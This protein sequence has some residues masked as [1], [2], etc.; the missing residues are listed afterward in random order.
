MTGTK[1]SRI[2]LVGLLAFSQSAYAC[3]VPVFRYA[4]ERWPAANYDVVLFH[5]GPLNSEEQA[6]RVLLEQAQG[7]ANVT[8]TPFDL[9]TNTDLS[10][11]KLWLRQSNAPLPRLVVRF[12]DS[13]SDASAA[14][15]GPL[16]RLTVQS[17]IDSPSR[18]KITGSL[19]KGDSAVWLLL[20]TGSPAQN[21][22][23]AALLTAELKKMETRLELPAPAPDDPPMRSALPLRMAFSVLRLSPQ[24]PA[25]G[26]FLRL[27]LGGEKELAAQKEPIAFPI[28][29][30][31]RMLAAL[32]AH[33]LGPKLI[34]EA[35]S[36]I[37][38]ACSCEVKDLS[39]GRDLLLSA[40]WNSIFA[41]PP[42]AEPE[43]AK[44]PVP[45]IAAGALQLAAPNSVAA[46]EARSPNRLLI[47]AISAATLL[48]LLTAYNAFKQ[49]FK[50]SA[51]GVTGP[52][53]AEKAKESARRP[54]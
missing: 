9:T 52:N 24:D 14:W 53:E 45:V 22:A 33:E 47:A 26:V 49:P 27:L 48:V 34:S 28:F 13:E 25:E 3:N 18:Q 54:S 46:P 37:S 23:L 8:V 21:D 31:G 1:L 42:S 35:C 6:A 19:L 32:T 39:P 7:T 11:Q 15:S 10:M 44:P 38:G 41:A 30:R 17:L 16:T 12:P 51:N 2:A 50:G 20:E 36:F 43:R 29:G 5:R 40:N 4:L